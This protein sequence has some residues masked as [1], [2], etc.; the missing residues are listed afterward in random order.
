MFGDGAEVVDFVGVEAEDEVD[1]VTSV[2]SDDERMVMMGW[3]RLWVASSFD[4]CMV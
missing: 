3:L 1:I 2:I 4:I